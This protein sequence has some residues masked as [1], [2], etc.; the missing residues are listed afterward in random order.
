MPP[1]C[2]PTNFSRM[3]YSIPCTRTPPLPVNC[4][5]KSQHRS[6]LLLEALLGVSGWARCPLAPMVP[7]ACSILALHTLISLFVSLA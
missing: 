7:R 6:H 3:F 4:S 5:S 2:L 1:R